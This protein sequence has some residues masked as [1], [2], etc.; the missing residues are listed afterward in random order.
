[1]LG[2][3]EVVLEAV[4]S[5]PDRNNT[6]PHRR[7]DSLEVLD[8]RPVVDDIGYD[9][10]AGQKALALS[11]LEAV[12]DASVVE[13]D[14]K[15]LRVSNG[16]RGRRAVVQPSRAAAMEEEPAGRG[17]AGQ[18]R[19]PSIAHCVVHRQLVDD[20]Q[21]LRLESRHHLGGPVFRLDLARGQLVGNLF[22]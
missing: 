6:T 11:R 4:R 3:V 16:F 1:E 13:A 18:P 14:P 10:D 7:P 9:I 22:L 15:G 5:L 19:E 8:L 21:L 12:E 20:W 17:G 2:G